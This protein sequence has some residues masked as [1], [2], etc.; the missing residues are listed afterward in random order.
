M[1]LLEQ[2][3]FY[4]AVQTPISWCEKALHC[5]RGSQEGAG[6]EQPSGLNCLKSIIILIHAT[7]ETKTKKAHQ[8]TKQNKKYSQAPSQREINLMDNMM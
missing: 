2:L 6:L 3:L 1:Y 4:Q 7:Y 8:K 5:V